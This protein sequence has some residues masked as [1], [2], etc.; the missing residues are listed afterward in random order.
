RMPANAPLPRVPVGIRAGRA[1]PR[2]RRLSMT[3]ILRSVSVALALAL[4]ASVPSA[5]A[6]ERAQEPEAGPQEQQQA[7]PSRL[8]QAAQQAQALDAPPGHL[9]AVDGDV[10]LE[11]G[12]QSEDAVDGMPLLVG[13]RL[14]A[15]SGHVEVM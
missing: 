12:N 1:L 8:V 2:R 13:D 4:L 7:P 10:V 11:R 5:Q 9:A 3:P 6:H 15:D 14:R